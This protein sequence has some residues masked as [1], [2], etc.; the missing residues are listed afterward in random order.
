MLTTLFAGGRTVR[1]A[2]AIAA[3]LALG[4]CANNQNADANGSGF[5]AGGAGLASLACFSS[6]LGLKVP[7]GSW[8]TEP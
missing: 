8:P 4:A 2:A 7:K 5:G 3:T 6:A 1:F